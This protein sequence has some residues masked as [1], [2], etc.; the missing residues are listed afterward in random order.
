MYCA[1]GSICDFVGSWANPV[2][3]PVGGAGQLTVIH[4][5]VLQVDF[6]RM[7]GE[8]VLLHGLEILGGGAALGGLMLGAIAVFIIVPLV[9][10]FGRKRAHADAAA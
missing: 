1:P 9:L 7:A 6:T 5:D 4:K 2:T 8:G 3:A 10:R